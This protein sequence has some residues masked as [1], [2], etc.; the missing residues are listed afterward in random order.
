MF[1]VY[2]GLFLGDVYRSAR[3]LPV[4]VQRATCAVFIKRDREVLDSRR[5]LGD[6]HVDAREIFAWAGIGSAPLAGFL[7]DHQRPLVCIWN[8]EDGVA[9]GGGGGFA[10]GE[11][12]VAYKRR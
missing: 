1:S 2:F 9:A 6:C 5:Q 11:I 10:N 4:D 3:C 7:A 12:G 8:G